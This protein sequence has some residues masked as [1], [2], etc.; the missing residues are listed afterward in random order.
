MT[1]VPL[2]L[3]SLGYIFYC[4][5]TLK[6]ELS[7][8]LEAHASD[9]DSSWKER[10]IQEGERISQVSRDGTRLFRILR[11]WFLLTSPTNH[12]STSKSWRAGR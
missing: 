6:T 4:P 5:E 8:G 7:N 11:S 10:M 2:V 9:A 12:N 1:D 3:A